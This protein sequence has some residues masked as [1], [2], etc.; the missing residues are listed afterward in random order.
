MQEASFADSAE[1]PPWMT[2]TQALRLA[3]EFDAPTVGTA[4]V[5]ASATALPG[6]LVA[7]DTLQGPQLRQGFCVG[8]LNLMI[9]YEDGNELTD[10]PQL[11][12]LPNAPDWFAGMTNL[13]G[14]L[15]SVFD[16]AV[17]FGVA[18][19][20]DAKPML[21][22]LGHGDEKAGLLIDGLPRRLRPQ[23]DERLEQMA[24]PS[25]VASCVSDVYRIEGQ[26][27]MDFRYAALFERLEA[28]LAS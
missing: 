3:F 27:W 10:L 24:V 13:H 25:H 16:P 18:H 7:A 9:R 14:G 4:A 20:P 19:Q 15:V 11:F 1:P 26:D 28:E 12:R 22:V 17:L 2:P 21:L 8:E 6:A 5:P 23:V